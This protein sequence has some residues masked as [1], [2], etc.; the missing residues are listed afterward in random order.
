MLDKQQRHCHCALHRLTEYQKQ[1][2]HYEGAFILLWWF[3]K[4]QNEHPRHSWGPCMPLG[5]CHF[6]SPE[7][8]FWPKAS[9]HLYQHTS[10]CLS[11]GGLSSQIL[12]CLDPMLF[13]GPCLCLFWGTVMSTTKICVEPAWLQLCLLTCMLDLETVPQTVALFGNGSLHRSYWI[14]VRAGDIARW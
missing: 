6:C 9:G 14:V 11:L 8:I 1:W 12:Q 3:L 7:S 2:C 4:H 13:A 10:T 5:Q